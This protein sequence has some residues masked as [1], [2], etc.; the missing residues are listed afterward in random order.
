MAGKDRSVDKIIKKAIEEGKFDDLQS[1]GKPLKLNENPFVDKEWQ[2]AFDMLSS[3]GLSLPWIEKR[4]SI[5]E[6]YSKAVRKI[7]RTWKWYRGKKEL[8]EELNLIEP[9]WEKVQKEFIET[10]AKLNQIIDIY[11]LEIPNDR[12]YRKRINAEVEISKLKK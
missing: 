9:E 2:L 5:E 12:F 4:N 1:K 8:N 6:G 3:Q 11:N 10:S 7:D